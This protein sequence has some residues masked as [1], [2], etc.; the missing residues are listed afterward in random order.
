M[1]IRCPFHPDEDPSCSVN[2]GKRVYHCFACQAAGNV[3]EFVHRMENRDGQA[4]TL[5]QAGILL[6]DICGIDL[7]G[8]SGREGVQKPHGGAKK[9]KTAE[10]TS[11][12][13]EPSSWTVGAARE[14]HR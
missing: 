5:R 1:K 13:P 7:G 14:G 6:A 9:G 12:R 8:A 2:L 3:L 11:P 4:V 10:T